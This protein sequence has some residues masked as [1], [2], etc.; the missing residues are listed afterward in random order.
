MSVSREYANLI[1]EALE[2]A[3]RIYEERSRE[4]NTGVDIREHWVFG[5]TSLVHEI[6][7]KSLRMVS[8]IK[9]GASEDKLVDSLLDIINYC[10]FAYA[11]VK[12]KEPKL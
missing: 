3:N 5:T 11:E 2:E 10:R 1:V 7:K 12:I 9:S 6:H 8:L 4:Y